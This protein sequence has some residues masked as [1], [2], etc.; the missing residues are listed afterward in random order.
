MLWVE[1]GW[2]PPA[3]NGLGI[4]DRVGFDRRFDEYAVNGGPLPKPPITASPAA[5]T[6]P[7]P[8]EPVRLRGINRVKKTLADGTEKFLFYHRYTKARLPD[9][10]D[11]PEFRAAVERLNRQV[12]ADRQEA[13]VTK[14]PS[15]VQGLAPRKPE[16]MAAPV[17]DL[18]SLVRTYQASHAWLRLRDSTRKI[19]QYSIRTILARYAGMTL[20]EVEARGSRTR[21]LEWRDELARKSPRAADTHISRLA[22]IFAFAVKREI[23]ARNPL[24]KFGKV[25]S[26]DRSDRIWLPEHI[27]A[28]N[29]EAK[30]SLQAALALALHTGQRRGDLLALRWSQFDGKAISLTQSKTGARVYIPCT[31]ALLAVLAELR[32]ASNHEHILLNGGE[33][34]TV[35]SFK[36]AWRYA[37][38]S[39]WPKPAT[40]PDLHFHDLRGTA[41]T[42]LAEAGCTVPEIAAITGHSLE[43]AGRILSRYLGPTPA[44]SESAIAK[45]ET[46]RVETG[47]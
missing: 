1:R 28:F 10:P 14:R 2:M 9:N 19:G 20:S 37:F 40:P 13:A 31:K 44:L 15:V 38:L 33:P 3:I 21:F 5:A 34:W 11:S 30:G 45:L 43:S 22:C 42:R 7:T 46:N 18:A 8:A 39:A 16:A 24:E 41:V 12:E 4:F 47:G 25:Y 35:E 32:A 23:L 29:A 17:E 27:A 26:A 36:Q 6:S